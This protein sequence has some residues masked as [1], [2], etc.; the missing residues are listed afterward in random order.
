MVKRFS[1]QMFGWIVALGMMPGW[2]WAQWES[3]WVSVPLETLTGSVLYDG[4]VAGDTIILVGGAGVVLR[5][6]GPMQQW[7]V[8]Q[9]ADAPT[10]RSVTVIPPETAIAISEEGAAYRSTDGG[11]TWEV[12]GFQ[13]GVPLRKVRADGERVA[14]AAASGSVFVSTDGG[15]TWVQQAL[16]FATTLHSIAVRR[17]LLVV[18]GDSAVVGVSSDSGLTWQRRRLEDRADALR[19]VAIIDDTTI[20]VVGDSGITGYSTDGG[21]TWQLTAFP[22]ADN[23]IAVRFPNAGEGWALAQSSADSVTLW[24]LT[25]SNWNW[26]VITDAITGNP[27]CSAVRWHRLIASGQHW[28][29]AGG[30]AES[31]AVVVGLPRQGW[32]WAFWGQPSKATVIVGGQVRHCRQVRLVVGEPQRPRVLEYDGET[33]AWTTFASLPVI[34]F[35]GQTPE[36]WYFQGA[37]AGKMVMNGAYGV[38]QSVDPLPVLWVSSDTGRSWQVQSI[39]TLKINAVFPYGTSGFGVLASEDG[40]TPTVLQYSADGG[41]TWQVMLDVSGSGQRLD[42]AQFPTEQIG[43]VAVH[44]GQRMELWKTENRGSTWTPYVLNILFHHAAADTM[45]DQQV[46]AMVAYSRL[47]LDMLLGGLVVKDGT[48]LGYTVG[49]WSSTDGG[50]SWQLRWWMDQVD[51]SWQLS[52]RPP[53]AEIAGQ[54][55]RVKAVL[56]ESPENGRRLLFSENGLA[57]SVHPFATN[58]PRRYHL[59]DFRNGCLCSVANGIAVGK[60]TEMLL[61]RF[62]NVSAVEQPAKEDMPTVTL[63]PQPATRWIA[64][65]LPVRWQQQVLAMDIFDLY[66]RRQWH[67]DQFVPQVPVRSL[68]AGTYHLRLIFPDRTVTLPFWIAR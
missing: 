33:G 48:S 54:D 67:L 16:P 13:F 55:R 27:G 66:G 43:W 10:L 12:I 63:F 25:T 68:P 30:C 50:S 35:A 64:V 31:A 38:I 22:T 52:S 58:D 39:G 8:Q 26:E 62:P 46:Y 24:R 34:D 3:T 20:V 57:W 14:V 40:V 51:P 49:L 65:R 59:I 44:T 21:N 29:V 19:D 9:L 28:I 47:H 5:A 36:G 45:L 60:E 15:D 2:G 7:T 53:V 61:M 41:A 17:S 1:M 11:Q 56:V 6:G 23:L 4:A 37:R 42:A 32:R 18:V